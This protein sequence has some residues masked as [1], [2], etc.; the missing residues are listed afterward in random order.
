MA[1]YYVSSGSGLDS[2]SGTSASSPFA[3]IQQAADRTQ[4]GDKVEVMAG[5]YSANAATGYVL[6]I[7]RSGAAGA[8][9]VYE[10]YNGARP[11]ITLP[12]GGVAAVQINASYVTFSG[13][14]LV[15]NAQ[16]V[17]LGQAQALAAQ[18]GSGSDRTIN[19][20]GIVV[21]WNG[22]QTIE[23]HV[24]ILNN[25]IHDFPGNGIGANKSDY[26]TIQGNTIYNNA[27]YGPYGNSGISLY[28]SHDSDSAT[29]YKNFITGNTLYNNKQLVNSYAIGQPNNISDGEGLLI[30]DNSNDQTDHVQYRGSTLVANNIAY[31]NGSVGL[32]AFAS[33]NVDFLYNTAYNNDPS[34]SHGGQLGSSRLQGGVYENNIVYAG[35]S[36]TGIGIDS[37]NSGVTED[38]NVIFGG[39]ATAGGPHDIQ[40]DP[41]LTDPTSANFALQAGSPAIGSANPAYT[42]PTDELGNA[43]PSN[44]HGDIGAL[45]YQRASGPPPPPPPTP[46]QA[47]TI[48]PGQGSFT[49]AAGNTYSIDAAK[50]GDENGKPMA[51]SANTGAMAY[52]N[53]QVYGQDASSHSW[54][55][56][57][58]STWTASSA[59]PAPTPTPTPGP[60]L[61]APA[62]DTLLLSLSED[63]WAGD[64]QAVVTVDGHAV[65][66]T[67][68][69]TAPH[70]QG[71]SQSVSLAGQWGPGAHD[72]GVQFINDAY[73]GTPTTDRNLYVNSVSLDGQAAGAAP[74]SLYAN[75]TAHL[76]TAAS[77]LVLQLSEDAWQGHA[78]FSV[79]VDGHSLGGP[80]SVTVSHASGGAQDFAFGTT[81]AAGTHDVAVSFLNDAWGG[82]AATDR[83]LYVNAVDANGAALPG[84]AATLMTTSTQHFSIVVAHA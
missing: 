59:P 58:Q 18:S 73:G 37:S 28:G 64:A 31:G 30:D 63:A 26:I 24:S 29:G 11:V 4:P 46:P 84:T 40:S 22:N 33:S 49:D 69:V 53:G 50:N 75:G 70:A 13:F 68:T 5:T 44:G 27:N 10:G 79:A 82:T 62:T 23:N 9:I 55:T 39:H 25:I 51:D 12:N 15:G 74:A 83:N 47:S 57:N 8:P 42:S 54:Y 41:K 81:M 60:T 76:A 14:E 48:T 20:G 34:G 52:A 21:S 72:V 67:V 61:P 1:T 2:N 65:G 71:K 77:P 56:W 16:S 45:E 80:Q 7:S 38:Y 3:T 36:G 78:Q 35:P 19:A 43:R 32:A 6:A 17:G 66:G